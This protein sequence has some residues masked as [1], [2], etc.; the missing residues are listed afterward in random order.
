MAFYNNQLF[1]DPITC[2]INKVP[3]AEGRSILFFCARA[4]FSVLDSLVTCIPL[5]LEMMAIE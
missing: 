4:F 5:M 3:Y 1:L 2:I